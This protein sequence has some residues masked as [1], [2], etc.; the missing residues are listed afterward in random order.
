MGT[1]NKTSR[2][3]DLSKVK[4]DTSKTVKKP[5]DKKREPVGVKYRCTC[6]GKYYPKQEGNFPVSYSMLFS[7]NNG[8]LTLC[9]PC[10]SSYYQQLI[11]YY[12]GNEYSALEHCCRLFDWYYSDAIA[13]SLENINTSKSRVLAYPSKMCLAGYKRKGESYLDT[14]K[15][16]FVD[17]EIKQEAEK[18]KSREDLEEKKD[19]EEIEITA[20]KETIMFFGFGYTNEE[21]E[22]L[23]EQYQD[24]TT[25]YECQTKTQEELFKNLCITQLIQQ[26]ASLQGNTKAVNEAMKTFQ[27]LLGTA[28]LKPNQLK[29]NALVDQNTFGTL[30]K[31][32]ENERPIG[33]PDPE[34]RDVDGI[35]EYIDT[36]F[37]GHLCKN[38]HLKNDKSEKYEKVMAKH[39]VKPP[40]Y[41]GDGDSEATSL[42]DRYSDKGDAS[43]EN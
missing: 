38:V 10:I 40:V 30:I 17:A 22:Y 6:C 13:K 11:G 39:T 42:L 1:T 33:E 19:S 29:D 34:W 24:W 12:S 7:G 37:L 18:I 8:Y 21:Y 25:R 35:E 9:K 41:E 43:D 26:K 5:A 3:P 15:E 14:V 20:S 32:I 16:R 28:N 31:K 4:I 23:E 27:E 36:Y 2:I